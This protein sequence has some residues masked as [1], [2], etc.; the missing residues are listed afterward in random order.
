MRP[1]IHENFRQEFPVH[2]IA[3][4]N[5]YEP[6]DMNI[7][8]DYRSP[9][10]QDYDARGF[11]YGVRF[12]LSSFFDWIAWA[13]KRTVTRI[14]LQSDEGVTISSIASGCY[15]HLVS[16]DK[17]SAA[18][19]FHPNIIGGE[20]KTFILYLTV[21]QGKEKLVT[22]GGWYQSKEL[23]GTEVVVLRPRQ[24]C[25]PDEVAI[26]PKVAAELL[27]IR[28]LEG[29]DERN[30]DLSEDRLR[31]LFDEIYNSDEGRAAPQ[32]VRS[33]LE[34]E[35]A[36]MMGSEHTLPSLNGLQLLRSTTRGTKRADE[37]PNFVSVC[38]CI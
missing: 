37:Q 11:T 12:G 19:V 5:P 23:V 22:I 21:P 30:Y 4:G 20:R 36:E 35:V 1:V 18:T 24:K 33:H 8:L 31:L 3:F 9:N 26:H 7:D 2:T 38:L 10:S 15:G 17:R 13:K 27:K 32:E 25:L 6:I 14:T 28:F 16:S 34:E 29:A